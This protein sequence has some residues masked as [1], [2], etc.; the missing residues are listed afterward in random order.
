LS[1]AVRA[2]I[3]LAVPPER[4]W[5]VLMDPSRL[6]E[7]VTLHA[8][9]VPPVPDEL[10][11]GASFRQ[12]LKMFGVEFE[13]EWT[14]VESE[15]PRRAS[16]RGAGPGGAGASVRYALEP[17]GGSGTLFEY[18]NEFEAPGGALGRRVGRTLGGRK[19]RREAERTLTNLK[20]LVE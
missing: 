9:L 8:G 1:D 5:D 2:T 6:G 19:S 13:V 16:W 14:V 17:L 4:V 7:W 15:R 10:A 20:A 18:A 3:E 11:E 12:R